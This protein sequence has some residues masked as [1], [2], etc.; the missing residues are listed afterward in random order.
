[1]RQAKQNCKTPF[2]SGMYTL[3]SLPQFTSMHRTQAQNRDISFVDNR[4]VGPE[5]SSSAALPLLPP[6]KLDLQH[7]NETECHTSNHGTDT[8]GRSEC[9]KGGTHAR[10]WVIGCW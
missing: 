1:M 4:T 10:K 9:T 5:S 8:V 6:P 3:S 7:P 2:N